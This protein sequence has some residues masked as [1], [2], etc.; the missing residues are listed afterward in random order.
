ML[1]WGRLVVDGMSGGPRWVLGSSHVRWRPAD[2]A[3]LGWV[4]SVLCTANTHQALS[5]RHV[6]GSWDSWPPPCRPP[7][8]LGGGA[9]VHLHLTSPAHVHSHFTCR[10]R[11]QRVTAVCSHAAP[12]CG[13]GRQNPQRPRAVRQELGGAASSETGQWGLWCP[14]PQLQ[15]SPPDS[16]GS[17]WPCRNWARPH[18]AAF[19]G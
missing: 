10:K 6:P 3:E 13:G 8:L 4:G 2:D 9:A 5:T 14:L 1:N 11:V 7:Q 15:A 17:P 12:G 19:L 18:S 16:A